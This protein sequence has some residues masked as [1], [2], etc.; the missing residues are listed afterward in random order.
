MSLGIRPAAMREMDKSFSSHSDFDRRG[1]CLSD[2]DY[3]LP[4]ELIAQYPLKERTRARLMFVPRAGGAPSHYTF[5]D[6]AG[7]FRA[8]DLLVLNNTK[9]IP[10]RLVGRRESGG[11]AEVFLLHETGPATW[12]ALVRPSGRIAKGSRLY[13]GASEELVAEVLDDPRKS[14]GMRFVQFLGSDIKAKIWK[15][16]RIPLPPY[17]NREDTE[18]DREFYQ[19]VFAAK[20]GAVAAPTAGLHFDEDLLEELMAKGVGI[21]YITLHTGYGTFQPVHA[22]NLAEH[23]MFF[24]E[25]EIDAEAARHLN[26]AKKGGRRIIACGTT[27]VRA[28][29]SAAEASGHIEPRRSSTNLFIY[30]PYDFKIV[31]GLITNFHL[32]KSTLL[33]LV[34]AFSGYENLMRAYEEAVKSQYRFYSYGDAML[35]L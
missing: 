21:I 6:I 32:P 34:S 8:G 1:A 22:E 16:G 13:L 26:A 25:Y 7:F 31:D 29:E 2:Y 35:I 33:M 17:I 20:E 14:S 10:A 12:E 5:K 23:H 19:T 24:E 30:P 3:S 9:V 15:A 28:L 11:Q 4:E 18:E 27:A